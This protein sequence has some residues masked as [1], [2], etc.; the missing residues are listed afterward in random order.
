[1][2]VG[3]G[4]QEAGLPNLRVAESMKFSI[5]IGQLGVTGTLTINTHSGADNV[6]STVQYSTRYGVG[7]EGWRYLVQLVRIGEG[8]KWMHTNSLEAGRRSMDWG[9]SGSKSAANY[10]RVETMHT[11]PRADKD[12]SGNQKRGRGLLSR[13]DD[14]P[15]SISV[16]CAE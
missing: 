2:V 4:E 15:E 9:S 13:C 8:A 12:T 14:N 6:M 10:Q 1:M 11:H 16:R 7:T 5:V 3:V